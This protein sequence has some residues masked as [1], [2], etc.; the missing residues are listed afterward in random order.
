MSLSILPKFPSG[1]HPFY[2]IFCDPYASMYILVTADSPMNYQK[3][4]HQ[5]LHY[6]SKTYKY[7]YSKDKGEWVEGPVESSGRGAIVGYN[8]DSIRLIYSNFDIYDY[9]NDSR[10][11][12]HKSVKAE[13]IRIDGGDIIN[14]KKGMV[15]NMG[16]A[17]SVEPKEAPQ[18]CTFSSSNPDICTIDENGHLVAVGEGECIIT[19]TS[20]M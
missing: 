9:D 14:M 18:F 5:T 4:N 17:V 2:C 15:W 6:Y 10:I 3:Y 12:F 7:D 20:K 19:I 1:L 11:V 8:N 16:K 13:E